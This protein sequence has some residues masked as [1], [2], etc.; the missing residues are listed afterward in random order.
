MA[1]TLFT[2]PVTQTGRFAALEANRPVCVT[3]GMNKVFAAL[4]RLLPRR[5]ALDLTSGA[6]GKRT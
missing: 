3:G 1:K 5:L 6:Y 2:P 4:G